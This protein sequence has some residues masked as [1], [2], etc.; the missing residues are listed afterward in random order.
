MRT[1]YHFNKAEGINSDFEY[2]LSAAQK[3]CPK[4]R[5]YD[6]FIGNYDMGDTS[7]KGNVHDYD[8]ISLVSR[9]KYKDGAKFTLKCS[10][11]KF[12]APLLVLCNDLSERPDGVKEYGL[13]FEVVA[14]ERGCNIWHIIP[15]PEKA[16]RPIKVLKT[17]NAQ[18]P[19]EGGEMIELTCEVK[20]KFLH[21]NVNGNEF[22]CGDPMISEEFHIGF[23]A[24]EGRNNIYSLTIEE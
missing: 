1:V 17:G 8:Y 21:I 5:L 9:K 10:F 22:I 15:F 18:F 3:Q 16:D 12:G 7:V 19:L 23:T 4:F 6:D 24:C 2:A 13:H 14:Y 11:E 20:G